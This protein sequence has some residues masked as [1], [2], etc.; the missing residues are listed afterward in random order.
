LLIGGLDPLIGVLRY[1]NG[2]LLSRGDI[3][4]IM[5]V[6]ESGPRRGE[7]G[8]RLGALIWDLMVES[9]VIHKDAARLVKQTALTWG[10]GTFGAWTPFNA[11]QATTI[12]TVGSCTKHTHTQSWQTNSTVRCKHSPP[13]PI[14]S[15]NSNPPS[16]HSDLLRRLN[17][18]NTAANLSAIC[19]LVPE[20]EEELL[21]SVDQP[22]E[23]R[24]CKKSG[25]DYLLCD[26]NRD[27]DSYRSPWSNEFDPPVDD[28][29]MSSERV[30][31]LEVRAN[32][33]F[34]VYR[35]L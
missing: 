15:H 25:R 32:E 23:V 4:N 31:R 9:T 33:A 26:Y 2:I 10:G 17:P 5:D 21:A 11:D 19:T 1:G 8:A 3:T 13:S 29:E 24:R 16:S 30:R 35:E 34:D 20:H 18:K 12:K 22:L 7:D 14:T 27:G 28:A 6:A